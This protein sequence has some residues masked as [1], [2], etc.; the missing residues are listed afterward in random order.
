MAGATAGARFGGAALPAR[1]IEPLENG[2]RGRHHVETL[3]R[4]LAQRAGQP[5]TGFSA[6][7]RL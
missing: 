1:W 6:G 2:E 5:S 3:A 7:R 4:Q